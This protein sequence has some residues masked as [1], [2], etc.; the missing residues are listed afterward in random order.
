MRFRL[1]YAEERL[2]FAMQLRQP[3]SPGSRDSSSEGMHVPMDRPTRLQHDARDMASGDSSST[4]MRMPTD[5]SAHLQRFA[6][7]MASGDSSSAGMH[8]PMDRAT[9]LQR[10]AGSIASGQTAEVLQIEV[11]RLAADRAMLASRTQVSW[12]MTTC[13]SILDCGCKANGLELSPALQYRLLCSCCSQCFSQ[14][15]RYSQ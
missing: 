12:Q 15:S 9:Q 1:S 4:D 8:M 6:G 11:Q 14:R 13:N 5:R 2:A 3:A 7:S 10:A